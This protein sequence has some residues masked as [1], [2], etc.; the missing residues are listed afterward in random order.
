MSTESLIGQDLVRESYEPGQYIF[1]EGDQQAHFYI[2]EKGEVLIF[3]MN[4]NGEKIDIANVI[5]GE[6]FGE[7]ALLDNAPRSAS[8]LAVKPCTLIKVSEEGYNHLLNEL[9]PWAMSMMRTL[10]V[11]LK[12][13]NNLLKSQPQFFDSET[14]RGSYKKS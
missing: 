1:F 13:L 6:Q 12:H 7:F 11:R 4:A 3:T 2:V 9:P 5:E 14:T 8:A 10:V